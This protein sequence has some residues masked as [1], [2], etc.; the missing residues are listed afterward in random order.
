MDSRLKIFSDKVSTKSSPK[1]DQNCKNSESQPFLVLLSNICH[2]EP[3]LEKISSKL[4]QKKYSND[5][6]HPI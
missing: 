5:F 2:F 4:R 3:F 1:I 6:F